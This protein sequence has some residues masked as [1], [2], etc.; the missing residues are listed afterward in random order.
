MSAYS[1]CALRYAFGV[2]LSV[3]LAYG[4]GW[5]MS[6]LATILTAAFLGNRA[7]R[8]DLKA[9]L[10]IL[11]AIVVI[12]GVAL[13]AT[14]HLYHYPLVFCILIST[15]LYLNFYQA[16]CGGS[17]LVV[18]L[19]TMAILL[20]PVVGG[21]QPAM[22]LLVAQGFLV[23]AAVAL[24][25]TQLAHTLVPGGTVPAL[26]EPKVEA[27]PARSAWLSTAVVLPVALLCV[28]FN[29]SGAVLPLILIAA[30]SQKADFSTGAKGGIAL[31]LANLGGGLAAVLFY[32]LLRITPTYPFLVLG[33]FAMALLFGQRLFSTRAAAPLYGS[34]FSTV[35]ILIGSGSGEYGGE[36]AAAF[37]QRIV[38][39]MLA[40]CYV[41]GALSLLQMHSV[42]QRWLSAGHWLS[43]KLNQKRS[44]A[45]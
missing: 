29:M 1:Q 12:F 40:V 27:H 25:C 41:V 37:Y 10:A 9:S 35:L 30:L 26:A 31:I 8:P 24:L 2:A 20:I 6:W 18:L 45:G 14:L 4:V 39:T 22:A 13:L 43:V 21:P 15:G 36:T 28:A 38:L 3:A 42:R 19:C 17:R 16:A 34:A 23:S 5:P 11:V 32:Q 44:V 7:P 33:L